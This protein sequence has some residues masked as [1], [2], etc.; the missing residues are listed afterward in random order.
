MENTITGA[1]AV[2][3]QVR[4]SVNERMFFKTMQ[5]LF[6]SSFSVMGELIQ[7][8]RRAGATRIDISLD[9]DSRTICV[10]DDGIGIE[11]F[12]ALLDL[13]TSGWSSEEVQLSDKPFGMGFFSAFY[14]CDSVVVYSRRRRLQASRDDI[15]EHRAI[16]I[17]EDEKHRDL[18]RIELHGVSEQLLCKSNMVSFG[19]SSDQVFEHKLKT[20]VS[21]F[22]V[23]IFLNGKELP[24]P[25][26][27]ATLLGEM[28]EVGFVSVAG[29]H[30]AGNIIPDTAHLLARNL[31]LQ[32]LPIESDGSSYHAGNGDSLP[33]VVV[34]LDSAS[35]QAR[36]P[37]RTHLYDSATQRNLITRA[38]VT[39]IRNHIVQQKNCLDP[40]DF[41][42]KYWIH[43]TNFGVAH[44][45]TDVPY[46]PIDAL[47]HCI[48]A[49]LST[50]YQE[51]MSPWYGT[52]AKLPNSDLV[53]R[54]DIL[55]GRVKVWRDTPTCVNDDPWAAVAMKVM[56]RENILRLRPSGIDSGHW[57]ND[58][59]PSY[60][61]LVFEV[62]ADAVNDRSVN[63]RWQ[64]SSANIR[65]AKEARVL[66]SST[67][68]EK[69]LLQFTVDNDWL[70]V[71]VPDQEV[72]CDFDYDCWLIGNANAVDHPVNALATFYDEGDDYR[73]EWESQAISHWDNLVGNTLRQEHLASTLARML[74][75]TPHIGEDQLPDCAIVSV[76][77]FGPAHEDHDHRFLRLRVEALDA[78]LVGRVCAHLGQHGGV[79]VSTED[80]ARALSAAVRPGSIQSH[81]EEHL[82]IRLEIPANA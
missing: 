23:P 11:N 59:T 3:Q 70:L 36:M 17:V 50:E 65:L 43:A 58:I 78:D 81:E 21:G 39:V 2:P 34:H 27:K 56:Q 69:L 33:S 61:D 24:R 8:A 30:R 46:L 10:T 12:E 53:S 16:D 26:A 57:I 18:T 63:Y 75:D 47:D 67:V 41:T 5:H 44:L 35:F 37:D 1:Q 55:D 45:F 72:V 29:I 62:E 25:L 54:Q 20:L 49:V 79:T 9:C 71:P 64:N 38:V 32:G 19:Q 4:A 66:I 31:W 68:D 22:P 77:R 13:A 42:R 40:A 52:G 76:L 7:N 73:E 6:S 14:A 28:T 80:M 74:A 48:N 51:A 82:Q 60:D 15:I